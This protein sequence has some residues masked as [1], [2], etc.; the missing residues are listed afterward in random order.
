MR[1]RTLVA[2]AMV[3]LSY[4][5]PGALLA[6]GPPIEHDP[7]GCVR[8]ERFPRLT[9]RLPDATGRARVYFRASGTATWYFVEMKPEAGLYAAALPK[10]KRS[11]KSFDYYIEA[12]DEAMT[13]SRTAEYGAAVVSGETCGEGKAMAAVA[14]S[15]SVV[16]GAPA[17]A[18]AV[19]AGFAGSGLVAASGAV[20]A[21]AAAAGAAGGGASTGLIVGIAAAG[22]AGVG[23]AVASGGGGGDSSSTTGGS[24]QGPGSGSTGGGGTSL[25]LLSIELSPSPPGI[26]VSVCAGRSVTFGG[27]NVTLQSDGSFNETWSVM[28]P[29][30]LRLAGRADASSLQATLTCVSGS[31]P[32]GS[33]SASGSNY[34]LSGTFSFGSSQGSMTVRR[35]N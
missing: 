11:T 30:T 24:S 34:T 10:P 18:P 8:A 13:Q 17:G 20:V 5:F 15:A 2:S 12:L 33:M 19:P 26:D 25:V 27:G 7:V 1:L 32:T 6:Q 3:L 35:L 22:A 28:T 21:G 14:S 4:A 29:N 23:V 9:A 16:V 31:G